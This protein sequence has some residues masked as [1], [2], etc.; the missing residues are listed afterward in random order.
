MTKTSTPARTCRGS[1]ERESR[2]GPIVSVGPAPRPARPRWSH[3]EQINLF[4]GTRIAFQCGVAVVFADAGPAAAFSFFARGPR[5]E[6]G[7][8]PRW[9]RP[10]Y[11]IGD[12]LLAGGGAAARLVTV[13]LDGFL[14][15]IPLPSQL[16]QLGVGEGPA[17]DTGEAV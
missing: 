1:L 16:A 6:A 11:S 8:F 13:G 10:A 9:P 14:E 2:T 17:G 5:L 12:L 3:Q 7:E 4:S 15:G